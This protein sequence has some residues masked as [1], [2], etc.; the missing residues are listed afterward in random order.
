MLILTMIEKF[1]VYFL[2]PCG[3]NRS[4]ICSMSDEF[5][6]A[7]LPRSFCVCIGDSLGCTESGI[8][9]NPLLLS[10]GNW[11]I[12]LPL[13][14]IVTSRAL[15]SSVHP[16]SHS[17]PTKTSDICV[18]LGIMWPSNY[19]SGKS[20]KYIRHRF[21]DFMVWPF[22]NPTWMGGPTFF[23]GRCGAS[24]CKKFPVDSISGIPVL[25]SLYQSWWMILL[26]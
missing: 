26:A 15:N 12:I 23:D 22:G 21:L 16:E 14:L 25:Y 9:H 17:F 8:L 4:G 20:G 13:R 24:T 10:L 19:S 6:C 1:I 3:W 2:Y 11:M 7:S 18:R 5:W